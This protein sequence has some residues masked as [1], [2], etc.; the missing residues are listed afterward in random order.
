MFRR[1]AQIE[2]LRLLRDPSLAACL[3]IGVLPVIALIAGI[4]GDLPRAQLA[5]VLEGPMR[6]SLLA[7]VALL[8]AAFG[9]VRTAA[10]FHSGVVGQDALVLHSDPPFWTRVVSAAVGAGV[11]GGA[12]WVFGFLGTSVINGLH[13][14]GYESLLGTVIVGAGAGVW[15]TAIGALVRSPLAALPLAIVSLSSAMFLSTIVP[16]FAAVLPLSSAL[17]AAG[18]PIADTSVGS[19]GSAV[20]ALLWLAVALG[21]AFVAYRRRSLLP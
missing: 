15:G 12:T 6:M 4:P 13:V 10:A 21:T 2:A 16:D 17:Q 20:I 5:H 18:S 11:I 8:G 7:N 1:A 3:G 19:Y 14:F 9:A